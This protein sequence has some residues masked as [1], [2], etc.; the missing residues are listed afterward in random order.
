MEAFETYSYC[1][2]VDPLGMGRQCCYGQIARIFEYFGQ[3]FTFYLLGGSKYLNILCV[4]CAQYIILR[5]KLVG[6]F[7]IVALNDQ[8]KPAT[9][10]CFF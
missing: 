7:R 9:K 8:C 3:L 6:L 4:Y 5:L 1:E 10:V 2:L